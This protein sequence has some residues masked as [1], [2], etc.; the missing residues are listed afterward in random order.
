M[1]YNICKGIYKQTMFNF[2][3]APKQLTV[4]LRILM[5]LNNVVSF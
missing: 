5:L 2:T 4:S 3:A 1:Y